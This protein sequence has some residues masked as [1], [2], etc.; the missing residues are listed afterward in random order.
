MNA[1]L[2]TAAVVV[3]RTIA[4]SPDMLFD[5]WLDP[6]SLSNWMRPGTINST[7][8][9]VDP[10]VGGE[11]EV[12]MRNDTTPI[13]HRGVYRVI[14]RPRRL[15]FT[16]ESPATESR[17]TLV[18]VDFIPKGKATEIVVTHEQL[19]DS[20]RPSHSN[21]WTSATEKLAHFVEARS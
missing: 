14:D 11:Y 1:S 7:Q 15:V 4:A 2:A 13:R 18:T 5:A 19:P 6:I 21:G 9:R 16:W 8:A 10:R 20:A 17:E 3:R 12:I